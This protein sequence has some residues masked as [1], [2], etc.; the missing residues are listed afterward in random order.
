MYDALVLVHLNSY[1]R[2]SLTGDGAW[3]N[4]ARSRSIFILVRYLCARLL[5]CIAHVVAALSRGNVAH[6]AVA[7]VVQLLLT[8][9][10]RLIVK[11]ARL[12]LQLVVAHVE[13]V[14]AEAVVA[15]T[16]HLGAAVARATGTKLI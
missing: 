16:A 11:L 3:F 4:E 13:C 2:V 5:L 12:L 7:A 9:T 14:A 6:D 15:A 8:T 1:V 10:H